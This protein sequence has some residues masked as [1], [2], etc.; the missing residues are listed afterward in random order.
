MLTCERCGYET[1]RKSDLKKH[2]RKKMECSPVFSSISPIEIIA[3]LD[4][5]YEDGIETFDCIHCLKKFNIKSNLSRHLNIC[6]SKPNSD[7]EMLKI[8][9]KNLKEK[10]QEHK[11]SKINVTNIINTNIN[12]YGNESLDHL[13]NDFLTSCFMFKNMQSLIENI[14]FDPD[15]PQNKNI[16]LKSL[17]H[18]LVKV[19]QDE[20]WNTKPADNVLDELVNKGQTILKK[21]FRD[22][23][24]EVEEEMSSEEIDEVIEWLAQIFENN[25]KIRQTLKKELLAL[26]D[27]FR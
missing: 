24:E 8:E 7:I 22:N 26:L 10:L 14:H 12:N 11:Y 27:N 5:K 25:E 2:L 23:R 20:K 15:C 9:V 18:K 1:Q 16:Q 13:P 21:H 6:K 4:K 3:K 19:Y 17:K